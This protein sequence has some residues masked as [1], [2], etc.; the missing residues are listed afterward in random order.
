LMAEGLLANREVLLE[1]FRSAAAIAPKALLEKLA[2]LKPLP[3][4]L[5]SLALAREGWSRF[6]GDVYLDRANILSYHKYPR[7]SPR[8]ALRIAEGVDIVANDI[9]VR[10]GSGT[11]PF[12]MRLEQGVLDTN[13]E[14]FVLAHAKIAGIQEN[15]AEIFAQSERQGIEWLIIRSLNQLT[16]QSLELP[17]DV[18]ARIERD[19]AE[20]YVVMVPNRA[21]LMEGRPVVGWWRVDPRNG[22]TLGIGESGA[23]IAFVEYL[24]LVLGFVTFGIC[25]LVAAAD[26]DSITIKDGLLCAGLGLG[27]GLATLAVGVIV[28]ATIGAREAGAGVAG[29]A[30]NAEDVMALFRRAYDLLSQGGPALKH[31]TRCSPIWP[32]RRRAERPCLQPPKQ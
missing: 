21:I 11:T 6:R 19:L 26:K 1:L 23:G 3:S 31:C 17:H 29:V 32:K 9:A 18:R 15:T 8:G 16:W 30:V 25:G 7:L 12:L 5:Y 4:Q 14:A 20:G 13:A 2:K 28:G 10:L 24:A 27:V 22:Q